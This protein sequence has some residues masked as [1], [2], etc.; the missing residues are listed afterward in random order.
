MADPFAGANQAK[1]EKEEK[2][3][4]HLRLVATPRGNENV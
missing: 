1:K 4:I 2:A 3:Y